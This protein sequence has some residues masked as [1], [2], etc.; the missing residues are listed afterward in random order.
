MKVFCSGDG[1]LVQGAALSSWKFLIGIN[2][3]LL[4]IF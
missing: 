3:I 1:R 2:I 4:K